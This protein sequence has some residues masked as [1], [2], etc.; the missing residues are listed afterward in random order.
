MNHQA[1]KMKNMQGF[2]MICDVE[3]EEPWLIF[4]PNTSTNYTTMAA[5]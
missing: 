4:I 1:L 2:G 5:G 3:T